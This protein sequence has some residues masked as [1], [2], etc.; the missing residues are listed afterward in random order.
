MGL[1]RNIT[2]WKLQFGGRGLQGLGLEQE[3]G[4]S[5]LGF[6]SGKGSGF[7]VSRVSIFGFIVGLR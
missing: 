4:F 5:G 6:H 2:P 1:Y 3:S 7:G